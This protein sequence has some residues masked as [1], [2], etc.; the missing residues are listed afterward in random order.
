MPL[1]DRIEIALRDQIVRALPR[2]QQIDKPLKVASDPRRCE[3]ESIKRVR[4]F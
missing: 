4:G 2:P 1:P 3:P